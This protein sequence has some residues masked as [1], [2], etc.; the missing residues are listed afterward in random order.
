[1]G[2]QISLL[3]HPRVEILFFPR[4]VFVFPSSPRAR[5]SMHSSSRHGQKSASPLQGGNSVGGKVIRPLAT[6]SF[7]ADS[8]FI[9]LHPASTRLH[10]QSLSLSLC[11]SFFPPL[12][13]SLPLKASL[14][15]ARWIDACAQKNHWMDIITRTQRGYVVA[16]QVSTMVILGTAALTRLRSALKILIMPVY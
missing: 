3:P 5:C 8:C 4:F 7:L 10:S 9:I 11:F 6:K 13:W 16:N 1:M 2:Q 12:R 15:L 14:L